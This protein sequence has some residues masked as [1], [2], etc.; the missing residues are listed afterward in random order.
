MRRYYGKIC[1]QANFIA[2]F[3]ALCYH[4]DLFR[5]GQTSGTERNTRRYAGGTRAGHPRRAGLQ[6]ADFN[7][8]PHLLEKHPDAVRLRR[9][10]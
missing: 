4:D 7:S 10:F 5:V 2:L 1:D 6:R 3:H 8:I 9:L